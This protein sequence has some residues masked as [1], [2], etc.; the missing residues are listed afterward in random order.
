MISVLQRDVNALLQSITNNNEPISPD[1]SEAA[2]S[3]NSRTQRQAHRRPNNKKRSRRGR[4]KNDIDE[5]SSYDDSDSDYSA[6]ESDSY[7]NKEMEQEEEEE[8]DERSIE[9]KFSYVS[10]KS[11]DD[12][13]QS[14]DDDSSESS[15]ES[16]TESSP[17]TKKK[18][19]NDGQ[20][21]IDLAGSSDSSSSSEEDYDESIAGKSKEDDD[22]SSS[23]HAMN[24]EDDVVF[25]NNEGGALDSKLDSTSNNDTLNGNDTSWFQPDYNHS[26]EEEVDDDDDD[27]DG[28]IEEIKH[29]HV[30]KIKQSKL[31]MVAQGFQCQATNKQSINDAN[32]EESVDANRSSST[33][34]TDHTPFDP[35]SVEYRGKNFQQNRCYVLKLRDGDAIVGIKYFV[36]E[37]TAHCI[38][39]APFGDTF[40]GTEE[41]EVDYTA[42]Y[43]M[44]EYVQVY[45]FSADLSLSKLVRESED[46]ELIP[47]LIYQSRTKGD[48]NTFGYFINP[49]LMRRKGKRRT[50][51]ITSLEGFVGAGGSLQGYE[52][53]GFDTVI[54]ID[55][56][57]DAIATLKLNNPK[58]KVYEGD[59]KQFMKDY[60]DCQL[61]CVLGKIDH[62]HWSSP[63][64]PFSQA[65]RSQNGSQIRSQKCLDQAELSPLLVDFVRMTNCS[66]AVFENV[67]GI[68]QRKNV[69]YLKNTVK[70]LMKLGYQV[71][72]TVLKA[73]DYG[74]AQKRPRFFMFVSKNN[75]PLPSIPAPTHGDSNHLWPYVTVK[76]ALSDVK[77]SLPNME[78][79][80][81]SVRPGQ[82]GV[83]R[84]KPHE[85]APTVRAGSVTPY[86]FA[87][88]RCINVREAA[89]L[90]GFPL[91]YKF[92]GGLSSQYRQV[93]NAV[94]VCL[95]TA[96][97]QSVKA[98]L[99]YEYAEVDE[100]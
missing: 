96:V 42:D 59:I 28:G 44:N 18:R 79:R 77:G 39:V 100:E 13:E 4:Y 95:S 5:E 16:G 70:E 58:V 2:R 31:A 37:D 61:K 32:D 56:D 72:C 33:R 64:Q 99:L 78:G 1:S 8:D 80:V 73:C 23:I 65:N 30:S 62:I 15:D 81:S 29:Y 41:T 7:K 93:G 68:Y 89:T 12:K 76:E 83:V 53:N 50:A 66:T 51:S 3:G 22:E 17:H 48:W 11:S 25:D 54:A 9:S 19:N 10:K 60:V 34:E 63:C 86:H 71:R 87:E 43:L 55:N 20:G 98:V 52:N 40:L 57:S 69:H 26:D 92:T 84:L 46:V 97:A 82:H 45:N 74:D 75:I 35:S 38:L 27:S 67:V 94:P 36:S 49:K 91:D 47:R 24:E 21:V 14:S 85:C 6:D 90:Q 88:D